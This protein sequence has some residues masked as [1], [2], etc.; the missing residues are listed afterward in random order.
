MSY[1]CI[2][3][4]SQVSSQQSTILGKQMGLLTLAF[5]LMHSLSVLAADCGLTCLSVTFSLMLRAL[6]FHSL[7]GRVQVSNVNGTSYG[8][9]HSA[10]NSANGLYRP[11]ADASEA[12][13]VQFSLTDSLLGNP[14]DLYVLVSPLCERGPQVLTLRRTGLW[15]AG[16]LLSLVVSWEFS[17]IIRHSPWEVPGS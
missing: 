7:K 14:T 8:Y 11:N 5:F 3:C 16:Q 13:L 4:V 2:Y 9:V 15:L 12:L 17:V 6:T 1:P 10:L